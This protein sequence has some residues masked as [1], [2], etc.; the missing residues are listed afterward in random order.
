M[1]L[2]FNPRKILDHARRIGLLVQRRAEAVQP[3]IEDANQVTEP[4]AIAEQA[5]KVRAMARL[6]DAACDYSLAADTFNAA[7]QL[8]RAAGDDDEAEKCTERSDV[9]AVAAMDRILRVVARED[10]PHAAESRVGVLEI[11]VAR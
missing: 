4:A 7:A 11:E 6:F 8:Y 3:L 2:Q 5:R 10:D 9:N 1:T